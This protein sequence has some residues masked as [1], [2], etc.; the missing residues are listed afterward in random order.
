MRL[1]VLAVGQLRGSAE[2]PLYENYAKRISQSGRYIGFD[3]L[4]LTE[5]K[6]LSL[7][8]I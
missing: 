7:I 8:H 2:T 4:Y 1:A 5:I 3:G 6:D